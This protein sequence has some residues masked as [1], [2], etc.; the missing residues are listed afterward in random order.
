MNDDGA[1]GTGGNDSSYTYNTPGNYTV[2]LRVT[3]S[4][5]RQSE[6]TVDISVED[7]AP[8][9]KIVLPKKVVMGQAATIDGSQ[10]SDPDGSVSAWEWDLNGDGGFDAGGPS[11]TTTFGAYGTRTIALRVTDDW[12]VTGVTSSQV[13]VLAPP[14]AA[15]VLTTPSPTVN[16]N[17]SFLPTG[18]SD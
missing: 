5:G 16:T 7:R 3:D 9:A 1:Y 6:S 8:V 4:R 17:T 10:S 12:G 18:S 14:V 11:V 2:H 15:G 13:K